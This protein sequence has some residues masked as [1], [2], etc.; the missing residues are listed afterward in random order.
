[1]RGSWGEGGSQRRGPTG[2]LGIHLG[3]V[4][5]FGLHHKGKKRCHTVQSMF[6]KAH[7]SCYGESVE[8]A[9]KEGRR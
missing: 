4:N 9:V 6:Q 7:C 5:K 2:R 8:R 3:H 1:M